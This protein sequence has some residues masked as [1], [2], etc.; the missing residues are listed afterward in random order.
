MTVTVRF[1]PSPTGLLH[2]GNARQ[3][4]INWLY[5]RAHG[6][7]FLL[8]SDDT[9]TERSTADFAAKIERDLTWL[10]LSWDLFARQSERLERYT[11]ALATLRLM[12]RA[13]RCYE[14]PE[15]L[16]LKRKQQLAAGRP[17]VYDRAALKLTPQDHDAKR[18]AGIAPHW[19]FLLDRET[20]AWDDLVRGAVRQDMA[21]QSDPVL[22][23]ADG[24]PTYILSSV[25][26]DIELGV[27]HII[28][29]E[30]HVTNSAAQIQLFRALGAEPPALGHTSLIVGADGSGLSKRIGSLSLEE[31][32]ETEGLEAMAVN[33]LLAGLGTNE[34]VAATSLDQL[35]ESFDIS[36]YGRATPRFDPAELEQLNAKILHETAYDSVADRLSAFG[37]G[38]GDTFWTA[39]RGNLSKLADAA[40]WWQVV[41]APTAPVIAD[42]DKDFCAA[43]ADL[44]PEGE[45]TAE[46]WGVWTGTLKSETGRKGKSL[47]MPLRKALTGR[48]RGP[49]LGDLLPLLGRA[50]TISRLRGET[51]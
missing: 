25:V 46:T 32:R 50:R 35:V 33:S 40:G 43:A 10:G 49:E 31:L 44:L 17:P 36:R 15:E 39:I 3:A 41:S 21:S 19:R 28:R 4:L 9:D 45:P 20:V 11:D 5:A 30:D 6:G 1:A 51:A 12:D 13:Y 37:V 8:R 29:G 7:Q 14:T 48:E 23:R 18:V 2:V 34:V 26:D 22:V 38:G 42:E 24:T 27:T 16:A 47:F